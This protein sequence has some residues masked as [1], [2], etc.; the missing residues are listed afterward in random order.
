MTTAPAERDES[1]I[2]FRHMVDSVGIKVFAD[3]LDLTTR[4]VN[5]ML[6]GAQPNPVRRLIRCMQACDPATG[7][8]T[9]AFICKELGGHF[10]K[11]EPT[12]SDALSNAV[13]ECAEAIAALSDG[14]ISK[15]GEREVREAIAAL[16]AVLQVRSRDG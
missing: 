6:A 7:D 16:L 4:Q 5:R 1:D 13:R 3:Q 12:I 9:L 2:W 14:E 15:D 10:V 11:D 8:A